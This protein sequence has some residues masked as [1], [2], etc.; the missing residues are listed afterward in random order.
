MTNKPTRP[1]DGRAGRNSWQGGVA[2][3]GQSEAEYGAQYLEF[4][5]PT[6]GNRGRRAGS[7]G[8]RSVKVLRI[9]L[10]FELYATKLL[11]REGGK[12]VN[13]TI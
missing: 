6:G 4:G 9:H 12:R 3:S 1:G 10:A 7:G 13:W 11:Q 2:R 8:A 5:G